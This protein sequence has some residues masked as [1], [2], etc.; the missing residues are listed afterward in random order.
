MEYIIL[1]LLILSPMTGY[2]LQQFIKNNLSLICSPSAGSMQTAVKK[3][4]REGKI[5]FRE[6]SEGGRRKKV[7]YITDLGRDAFSVWISQPMQSGRAKNMEL[8]RLF[9]LGLAPYEKRAEAIKD[10]I[11]QIEEMRSVLQVIRENFQKITQSN[12]DLFKKLGDV[13]RFQGY[14]IEYG[15][16]AA[17]FEIGF[18]KKLLTELEEN[19]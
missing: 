3:L 2:E 4:E 13:F 16:A 5:A 8:S 12:P 9:F 14:T 11:S 10:Y 1:G 18:Y 19:S 17:D 7:F 15:I 6:L